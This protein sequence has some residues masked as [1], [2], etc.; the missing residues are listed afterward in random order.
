[1]QGVPSWASCS[2]PP[3]MHMSIPTT[4]TTQTA[5]KTSSR[6]EYLLTKVT[7]P[8]LRDELLRETGKIR[9]HKKFGLVF[10]EHMPEHVRLPHLP[11]RSGSKVV[12][13]DSD[14]SDVFSVIEVTGSQ[15]HILH[16]IEG[17]WT[18]A[19]VS[20]LVVVKK[21]GDPIY[22]SLVPVD[23]VTRSEE[24]PYHAII[25]AENYHALQLLLYCYEGQVDA[26][27]IDPPYNTGARDWKYN[28]NY[29]D[30]ND[31][32]RHS[33]WLS[34]MKRRLA[35]AKR[36]LK[37][38]GVL[39][40]AIDDNEAHTL[41]LLL[42]DLF[43][44][45][46]LEKV[47]IVHHP[48][49]NNGINVW[50][51]HEYAFFA[52]PSGRKSL[53]GYKHDM[54]EEYWSLKRSGTGAGN[55][56]HGRPKMFY[57]ILVDEKRKRI[58]GVG[59]ELGPKEKYTT[60]KTK[61]GYTMVYPLD[62]RGGERVWR[63]GMDTMQ[64]K[65]SRGE[66]VLR[67]KDLTTLAVVAPP[68]TH[69]PIFS[70]WNQPQYNAGTAGANLLTSIMGTAN[71]FP[72]PKS[73][74]TVQDCIGAVCRD[75]PNALILDFFAGSGTTLHATCLLNAEDGG[76]RRCIL[77]TNNE[78]GEK[79]AKE[80]R[81]KGIHPGDERFEKRGICE[82]VTWPRSRYVVNGKRDDNTPLPG[83]Y[84]NGRKL[85]EGFEENIQYFRLDY[86]DPNAIAYRQKLTDILPILWLTAG[87]RGV[88]GGLE[89]EGRWFIPKGSAY[90]VLLQESHIAGFSEELRKHDGISHVFLVTDAEEAYR[91]MAMQLP[92][93]CT[94]KMLYKSYLDNF[95][96]NIPREP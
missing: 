55:W 64:E 57:A 50:A 4:S 36:L 24:K 75:R 51:T 43:K 60:G 56:R 71:A 48:Q 30:A 62:E 14:G 87:A 15:A 69:A 26:I 27:Y 35:V 25:N 91:E 81:E 13:R 74:Y 47:I 6:L 3:S 49:G 20:D 90:A 83:E 59:K 46:N 66:I 17:Q 41:T 1:M 10:E 58:V 70:V 73:L 68:R 28:N 44:E 78:V 40:I 18:E 7:D 5:S 92:G 88:Y 32:F 23:H 80:L 21:F 12:L 72:F 19:A 82:S 95:R 53:F 38:D 76:S 34:M 85:S 96:I 2:V 65:I 33:K 54:K 52:V 67:G 93:R 37:P 86:L 45:R 31:H 94:A 16:E 11:V 84:L 39:V 9:M 79:T 22:P 77:V 63:Y 61:E 89:K 29:V 42:Q 8:A